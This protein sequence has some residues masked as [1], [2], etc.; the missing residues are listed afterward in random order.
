MTAAQAEEQMGAILTPVS[1]LKLIHLI[2]EMADQHLYS[3]RALELRVTLSPSLYVNVSFWV[4][5]TSETVGGAPVA[6]HHA[7]SVAGAA[8]GHAPAVVEGLP[9]PVEARPLL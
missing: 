9:L 8:A 4:P 5:F 1:T 6:V 3:S 2:S 7:P